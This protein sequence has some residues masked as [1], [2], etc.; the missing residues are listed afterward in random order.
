LSRV[1]LAMTIALPAIAAAQGFEYAAGTSQYK[2]T[3]TAKITQQAMG[4]SQEAETSANQVFTST[5]QKASKDTLVVNYVLDSVAVIGPMGPVMMSDKLVGMKVKTKVSPTGVKYSAEG[6]TDDSI[7]GASQFI[8]GLGGLLPR[9][10]GSMVMGSSW[11]DTTTG[12]VKQGGLDVDRRVIA[13]YTVAGDTTVG[14]EK[15]WKI[16][17][18]STTALSGSGA[19]QG[20]AMTME[21]TSTGKSTFVVTQ[22]GVLLGGEGNEDVNLKI[23]LAANGME[24][25]VT[26][27]VTSKL[28]KIK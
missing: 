18:Q 15:G 7:P 6:A 23:V 12:K 9:I 27:A 26:Q 5:I 21:G 13:V 19:T 25:G 10:R 28:A 8:D 24:I 2:L 11:T 22:K 1:A 3:Q 17:S 14:A 4:Q 20:Q 16:A